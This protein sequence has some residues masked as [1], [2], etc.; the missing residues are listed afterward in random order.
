MGQKL[1]DCC[2][3][4]INVVLLIFFIQENINIVHY[5]LFLYKRTSVPHSIIELTYI[6]QYLYIYIYTHN[7]SVYIIISCMVNANAYHSICS[8]FALGLYVVPQ[9]HQIL[10]PALPLCWPSPW[11]ISAFLIVHLFFHSPKLI[12]DIFEPLFNHRSWEHTNMQ[13]HCRGSTICF[14]GCKFLK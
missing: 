13:K 1:L 5:I 6:P 2:S 4:H 12:A 3:N 9:E 8:L 11:W 10:P 7:N 14:G